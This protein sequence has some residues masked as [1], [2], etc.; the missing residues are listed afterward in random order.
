[1]NRQDKIAVVEALHTDFEK[2]QAAF[3]IGVKGLT[4][5]QMHKLR[6]ELRKSGGTFKVAK[7]RLI[8]RAAQGLQGPEGLMSSYKDQIGLVFASQ[9]A[10]SVAKVLH[11][12]SKENEALRV[13]SGCMDA[14]ILDSNTIIR[15][16]SLPS[17]EIMLAIVCGT[18]KAPIQRLAGVLAA[19]Q[20]QRGSSSVQEPSADEPS[21]QEPVAQESAG[22]SKE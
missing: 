22:E 6:R 12:F 17:R 21:A 15:I 1:M 2:S 20:E 10:T 5:A 18:L 9:E 8:K 14:Q 11:D 3:V 16:A 19:L 4:V 7:A 13:I